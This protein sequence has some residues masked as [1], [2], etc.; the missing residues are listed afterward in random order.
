MHTQ[1]RSHPKMLGYFPLS[2]RDQVTGMPVVAGAVT[3]FIASRVQHCCKLESKASVPPLTAPP[4]PATPFSLLLSTHNPHAHHPLSRCARSVDGDVRCV[5]PCLG[6]MWCCV[7]C[8]T[9]VMWR[10]Q[11]WCIM[12]TAWYQWKFLVLCM[13]SSVAGS[14]V[15]VEHEIDGKLFHVYRLHFDINVM[16]TRSTWQPCWDTACADACTSSRD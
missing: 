16:C 13:Q 4:S 15:Y 14:S 6:T 12:C 5:Q 1:A 3:N 7:H 2:D 11:C 10:A 9:C 8:L